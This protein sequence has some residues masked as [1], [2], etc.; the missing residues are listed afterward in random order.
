[1]ERFKVGSI[2]DGYRDDSPPR[3]GRRRQ[4]FVGRGIGREDSARGTGLL[5]S[6]RR[7]SVL[8]PM[9]LH[10]FAQQGKG[11]GPP[12]AVITR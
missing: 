9:Q 10:P 5:V 2:D 12:I 1:M 11:R 8:D 3:P 6:I 7:M 4:T